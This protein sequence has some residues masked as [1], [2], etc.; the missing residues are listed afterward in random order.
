MK[1]ILFTGS[2]DGIGLEA[3]RMLVGKG[4]RVLMHGRNAN[5]LEAAAQELGVTDTYTADLSDLSQVYRMA[6]DVKAKHD[7]LDVLVNNAG[8]FKAPNADR[9]TVNGLDTRVAVN[10][11]APYIL[12]KELLPII[13]K[14]GRIINVSS[15]AQSPVDLNKALPSTGLKAG[16]PSPYGQDFDAYGQSKLAIM[17]WNNVMTAD[18]PNHILASLNPAS[19]IGTKMVKEGFGV[20]GKSLDIGRDILVEAAVGKKFERASGKYFDNDRGNFGNPHPDANNMRKC[21]NFVQAMDEWLATHLS[22]TCQ[23][24]DSLN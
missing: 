15:A 11:I 19:M 17:M 21:R 6:S 9:R 7:R 1:T 13:P 22:E 8:V 12:T 20:A 5:K 23:A 14:H 18:H 2:T 16:S 10:A 4:H 3:V 24:G